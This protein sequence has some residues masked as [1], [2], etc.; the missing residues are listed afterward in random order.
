MEY[1]VPIK[2]IESINR[3]KSILWKKSKRDYLLFVFGI[4]TGIRISDLLNLQ[5]KD[6]WDGE[7]AVDFLCIPKSEK[8]KEQAIFINTN[9]FI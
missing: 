6:V 8:R 4:N 7:K 1:V 9:G 2:D 5:V 3:I